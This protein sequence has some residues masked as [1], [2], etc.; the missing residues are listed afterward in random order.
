MI[1]QILLKD[2][3]RFEKRFI[4]DKNNCW[5]WKT[6]KDKSGYGQFWYKGKVLRAHRFSWVLYRGEIP[7]EM[8]VCHHCDIR[9]CQNP[10]HLFLGSCKE[11]IQ[12]ASRKKRLKRSKKTKKKMSL[13]KNKY[14][15]ESDR[16]EHRKKLILANKKRKKL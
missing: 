3:I 6:S 8:Y 11:N 5:I 12:D 16:K 14:W 9:T 4:K 15:K 2:I 1:H 7:K 13:A 10:E